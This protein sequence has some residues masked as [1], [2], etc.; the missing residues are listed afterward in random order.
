MEITQ[1]LKD[2]G[3]T[4]L[5]N[6]GASLMACSDSKPHGTPVYVLLR[7]KGLECDPTT[8]YFGSWGPESVGVDIKGIGSITLQFPELTRDL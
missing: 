2:S 6:R 1:F 3:F 7:E 5:E 8:G 4:R